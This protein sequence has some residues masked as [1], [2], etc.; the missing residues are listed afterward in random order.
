MQIPNI[1]TQITII[2]PF[3]PFSSFP[4]SPDQVSQECG[5]RLLTAVFNTTR[6]GTRFQEGVPNIL[7]TSFNKSRF[8][9]PNTVGD[10]VSSRFGFL[11]YHINQIIIPR[12]VELELLT[13]ISARRAPATS[14]RPL[15]GNLHL[16]N[17]WRKAA[18]WFCTRPGYPG[19]LTQVYEILNVRG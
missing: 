4:A 12:A 19:S 1:Y 8:C 15:R 17:V 7:R 6:S 16:P 11:G 14:L 10:H 9:I 13:N 3:V 18:S 2:P 5:Y